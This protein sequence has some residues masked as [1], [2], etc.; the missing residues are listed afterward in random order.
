MF[1][2]EYVKIYKECFPYKVI[3]NNYKNRLPWLTDGLKKSIHH[4]NALY[5]KYIK[6]KTIENKN[7]YL[8]KKKLLNCLMKKVEREYYDK[9]FKDNVSNLKKSWSI[10]KEI[11]NKKKG[12]NTT[13]E[14][15]INGSIIDDKK[16]ICEEFNK[17]Y[18]NVGPTLAEKIP[19]FN[20]STTSYM[21]AAN[22][23]SIYLKPVCLEELKKIISNLKDS[24]AGWDDIQAKIL[25]QT[26]HLYLPI[27]EHLIN[28]SLCEG[29]F[30]KELKLARVIPLFKA[31][32]AMLVNNYRP[33]SVLPLLSKL[34]ERVMYNRIL[35]FINEH[36]ILYKFQFGFREM[37]GT[38]IA[39][40]V[41]IDKIM[42]AFHEGDMVL[43]VFLDLSKAFDTVNHK[44]LL[45]KMYHYGIR[46]VANDWL[47]S[48]LYH[49]MIVHLV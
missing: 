2:E 7:M 1:H 18:I 15:R 16:M 10:I 35:S 11:I 8:E 25:K 47:C 30:P 49:I 39:L 32:D 41:L 31:E 36:N 20:R 38:D 26:A 21:P 27:I 42:E 13:S 33:V 34:F 12:S 19:T 43:G 44:I 23:E 24:S 29:V 3:K 22:P 40:I 37:H 9:L 28:L 6:K 14:F 4:K 5:L 17:F 46:G 48:Y 45:D